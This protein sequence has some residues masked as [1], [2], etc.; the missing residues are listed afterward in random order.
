MLASSSGPV[1]TTGTT[2]EAQGAENRLIELVIAEGWNIL[3]GIPRTVLI[4]NFLK[5][6][7]D[8]S[9][10]G[11]RTILS[12]IEV[13]L[14]R[15]WKL[16]LAFLSILSGDLWDSCPPCYFGPPYRTIKVNS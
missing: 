10:V 5:G 8:V 12:L 14:K 4:T 11:W 16:S 13:A 2:F 1:A 6:T 3:T 9:T 7:T 15:S